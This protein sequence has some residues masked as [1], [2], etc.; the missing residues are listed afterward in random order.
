M[1]ENGRKGCVFGVIATDFVM[2]NVRTLYFFLNKI[3]LLAFRE[4][5]CIIG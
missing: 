3:R 1:H 2:F 5:P 4:K